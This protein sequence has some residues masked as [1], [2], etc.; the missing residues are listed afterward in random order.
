MLKTNQ[1]ANKDKI[2]SNYNEFNYTIF[3]S[4]IF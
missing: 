1:G 3:N 4:I 2:L